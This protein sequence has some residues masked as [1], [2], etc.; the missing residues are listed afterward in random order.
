MFLS[1]VGLLLYQHKPYFR[2]LEIYHVVFSPF[3]RGAGVS[4]LEVK[5][6]IFI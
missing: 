4:F 1:L 6:E 5:Y 2:M 3:G